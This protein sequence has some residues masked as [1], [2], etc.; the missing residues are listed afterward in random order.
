VASRNGSGPWGEKVAIVGAYESPTRKAT[1]AHPFALHAECVLG[2]VQDAGLAV[3][4]V[5][6]FCTAAGFPNEGGAS[7]DVMDVAEWIG[8]RP[9]YADGTDNGGAAPVSHAGH[10]AAAIWSGMADVVVVSYASARSGL[11]WGTRLDANLFPSGAGQYELPFGFTTVASYGLAAQRHMHDYGTTSEQLAQIA[12]QVRANAARNEHARYRDPI[13]VDDVVSSPIIASPLHRYDCCVVTD[14]GGAI[15]LAG[16]ERARDCRR[17]PVWL[18]GFGECIRQVQMAQMQPL[19]RTAAVESGE[20]AFATA[21]VS[22]DEIDC[23]QLYDS[24]TITALM[25]LEDLGFC[26]KG[27]GGPFVASGAIAPDGSTPIQTDGGGLS[28]NHPGR[29]GMFAMIEAVRQ[30]RGDG[31]GVQLADPKLALA[32]GVGGSLS[33]GATMILGV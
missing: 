23:V 5:D 2:A 8:I 20:L 14:S 32:H 33:S 31:P 24:F 15:V 13:T 9:T 30:L 11:A 7:Q 19:T 26:E 16:A 17:E 4:D 27:E 12:V 22:R 3:A 29:R 1:G 18:R 25:T 10:A 28:S 21:G 6:G